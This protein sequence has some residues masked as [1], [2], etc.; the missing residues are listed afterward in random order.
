VVEPLPSVVVPCYPRR[1]STVFQR[2]QPA[3][4]NR[5]ALHC[6]RLEAVALI[7]VVA[8]VSTTP[9]TTATGL[10]ARTPAGGARPLG[11]V[12]YDPNHAN[13][14]LGETRKRTQTCRRSHT[15]GKNYQATLYFP[16]DVL[17][18][19]LQMLIANRFRYVTIDIGA[20]RRRAFGSDHLLFLRKAR[21][22]RSDLRSGRSTPSKS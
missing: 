1:K 3:G 22:G 5:Q 9:V 6:Y 16:A 15:R 17:G 10:I 20:S 2:E 11:Q 18:P 12:H 8:T 13:L 14:S 7:L 21:R 19:I 4:V